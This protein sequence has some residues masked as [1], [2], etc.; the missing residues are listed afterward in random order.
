M[1][2]TLGDVEVRFWGRLREAL[3][4]FDVEFIGGGGF[5]AKTGEL[6]HD[7]GE[8]WEIIRVWIHGYSRLSTEIGK[9][10]LSFLLSASA[11]VLQIASTIRAGKAG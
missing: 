11:T 2:H 1:G 7:V 5:T 9:G 6:G 4:L 3:G 10:S 8:N